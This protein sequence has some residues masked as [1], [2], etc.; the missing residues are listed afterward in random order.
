MITLAAPLGANFSDNV[1]PLAFT[2]SDGVQTFTNHT[3]TTASFFFAT[4]PSGVIPE[5]SFAI[6]RLRLRAKT[7]KDRSLL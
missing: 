6:L 4:D 1:T 7:I 5:W 3:A 2:V